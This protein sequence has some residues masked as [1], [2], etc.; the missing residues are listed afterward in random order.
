MTLLSL[1]ITQPTEGLGQ[2]FP[3]PRVA[4]AIAKD[5]QRLSA[6]SSIFNLLSVKVGVIQRQNL[7][8]RQQPGNF[9]RLTQTL[10]TPRYLF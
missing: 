8:S 10:H 2:V 1:T 9:Y 6:S 4:K 7:Q 3:N 5:I